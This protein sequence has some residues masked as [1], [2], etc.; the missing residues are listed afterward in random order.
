[1]PFTNDALYPTTQLLLFSVH[2]TVCIQGACA[3]STQPVN[4]AY[5]IWQLPVKKLCVA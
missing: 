4:Y 2:L 1:M 5:G 3:I